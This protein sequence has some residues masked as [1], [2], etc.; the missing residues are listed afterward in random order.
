M[1]KSLFNLQRKRC[2]IYIVYGMQSR[3]RRSTYMSVLLLPITPV[4]SMRISL[5]VSH[6]LEHP[7]FE[8]WE[9]NIKLLQAICELTNVKRVANILHMIP[10]IKSI[11]TLFALIILLQ[12]LKCL[13][14]LYADQ[15]THISINIIALTYKTP[16]WRSYIQMTLVTLIWPR[17]SREA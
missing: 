9:I 16:R 12:H 11:N 7:R 10:I 8:V 5:P 13:F 6:N 2:H 14:V 3:V 17:V 4:C 15:S 1:V